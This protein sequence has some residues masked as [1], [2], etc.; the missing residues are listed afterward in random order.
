MTSSSDSSSLYASTVPSGSPSADIAL[1]PY[2][3][4]QIFYPP[5][6]HIVS[7]PFVLSPSPLAPGCF[8]IP[9]ASSSYPGSLRVL[10]WNAGSLRAKST[11]LPYFISSHLVSLTLFVSRNL[12]LMHF[13][14][15]GS[16]DFLLC[17]LIASTPGLAFFLPIIRALAAVSSF[18]SGRAYPSLNFLSPLYFHS[19]PT[20]IT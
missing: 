4:L 17:D 19:T 3:C 14:L 10:Q 18:S 16:L 9:C 5:S 8:S 11:E 2:S 15:S 6:A 13:P 7:S 12:T 20:L 1:P